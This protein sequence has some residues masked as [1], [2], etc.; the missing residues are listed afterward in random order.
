MSAIPFCLFDEESAPFLTCKKTK[1][2]DNTIHTHYTAKHQQQYNKIL[3]DLC[4]P[5]IS[6]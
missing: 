2:L 1:Q 6:S 3:Q 5:M 4:N